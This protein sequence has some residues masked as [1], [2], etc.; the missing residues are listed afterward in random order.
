M[1]YRRVPDETIKRLPIYLRRAIRLSEGS[2]KCV[3]SKELASLLGVTPW[4]IRKDLS[5]FGGFGTRG[6]GYNVEN[7]ISHI[8]EILRLDIVRKAAL[9]GVGNL[10]SAI[11]A[12][13]GFRPYWLEIAAAFDIDKRKVGKKRN[14]LVVEDVALL[15]T[16]KERR[17]VLGIIAVPDDA[18]QNVANDLIKVGVKAI[19]NF[20]PRYI[21]APKSVKVIT[22]D[23]ALYLARLPYYVPTKR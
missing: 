23:I 15:E 16:L 17:I 7:L 6:V 20:A 18:A 4:Q 11:L 14:G 22:I 3:S 13:P 9:V 5:Y 8:R 2:V 1:R 12:F 10:G 21:E 19:L